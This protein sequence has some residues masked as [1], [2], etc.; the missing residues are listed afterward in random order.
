MA[1]I[2]PLMCFNPHLTSRLGAVLHRCRNRWR[3]LPASVSILAQPL[4]RVQR[5][6]AHSPFQSLPNLSAGCSRGSGIVVSILTQPIGWVQCGEGRQIS[7]L[8]V[9]SILAQPIGWVQLP[10]IA[11]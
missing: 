3:R 7:R 6:V 11:E 8:V 5:A 4:G 10:M 1:V 2:I 9:V